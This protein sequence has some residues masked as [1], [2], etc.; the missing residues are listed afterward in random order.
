MLITFINYAC[1]MNKYLLTVSFN[2][3]SNSINNYLGIH[4]Q[5]VKS[6]S[7]AFQ[8]QRQRKF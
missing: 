1:G 6:F 5:K 3:V 2:F 4:L 8:T 7:K